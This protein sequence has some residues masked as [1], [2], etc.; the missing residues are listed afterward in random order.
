MRA[1]AWLMMRDAPTNGTPFLVSGH[2]GVSR[3]LRCWATK[4]AAIE[5][6]RKE[7]CA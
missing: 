7:F 5:A 6:G 3:S 4:R 2:P 1:D